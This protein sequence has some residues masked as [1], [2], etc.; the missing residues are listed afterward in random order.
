MA[1]LLLD[2]N[3]P[4]KLDSLLSAKGWDIKRVIPG[5]SDKEIAELAKGEKRTIVTQDKHLADIRDFLPR[6]FF[7]II[8]LRIYPPKISDILS[9]LEKVFSTFPEEEI[10]GKLIVV[11]ENKINIR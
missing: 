11:R 6:D 3:L 7:G 8:R 10:R 9:G 1:K 2:E 5:S 4:I